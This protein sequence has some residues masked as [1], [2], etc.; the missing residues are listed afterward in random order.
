MK[1]LDFDREY[2]AFAEQWIRENRANYKTMDDM[3]AHLP[4]MF[5]RWLNTPVEFLEGATPGTYFSRYSDPEMLVGWML[6]YEAGSV[7]VPDLL[8]ER[9]VELGAGSIAPLLRLAGDEC[10][11][12]PLRI[13]AIN[14]LL[15]L[16]AEEAM[17]L[18]LDLVSFRDAE[19]ELADVA[20]E[21]LES[22]GY[23]A[24]PAMLDRLEES[25]SYARMT[26][27]DLL[28]NFPG[29]ERI[30]TYTVKEFASGMGDLALYASYLAKLG[31]DR[32]IA[33]LGEAL[34][35]AELNYLEYIEI[36]NAIESLGG[37]VAG[38]DREFHGDPYYESMKQI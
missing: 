36:R 8:L 32:A 35:R 30:Y 17:P 34:N 23:A 20:S 28:C 18:C 19:D 29:D 25:S 14:L 13:T 21:L 3:E 1:L 24:V 11:D 15:E 22:L 9:I 6:E 4:D 12:N 33:P 10:A 27:L 31:D 37:E 2:A 38:P 26:F 5:L 7:P 16:G